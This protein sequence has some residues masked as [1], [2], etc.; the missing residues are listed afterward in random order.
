MGKTVREL[1]PGD[2][3][4][5]PPNVPHWHGATPTDAMTQITVGFSPDT[6]WMNPVSDREYAGTNQQ[7]R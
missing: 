3:A 4:Y 2:T 5:T 6:T 7:A 1:R